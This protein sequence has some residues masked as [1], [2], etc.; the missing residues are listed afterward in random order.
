MRLADFIL[1][2]MEAIVV[3]WE[4]FAASLLPAAKGM[5]SLALRDHAVQIL[6]AVATDMSTYQSRQ[7][8]LD[9]SQG[10]A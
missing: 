3:E 4:E 6:Q 2:N 7:Q 10:L 8:Q 5:S 9:K 1:M